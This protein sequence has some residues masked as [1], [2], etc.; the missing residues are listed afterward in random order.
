MHIEQSTE[1][2][3]YLSGMI[4]RRIGKRRP[5][6]RFGVGEIYRHQISRARTALIW[7][8]EELNLPP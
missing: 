1:L 5:D 8:A 7:A 4:A 6:L 2:S 3:A